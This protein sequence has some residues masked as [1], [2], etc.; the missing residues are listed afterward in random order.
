MQFCWN[1][2]IVAGSHEVPFV[3]IESP[4][5][6]Y[7]DSSAIDG[8]FN[9]KWALFTEVQKSYCGEYRRTMRWWPET[10][11]NII[12]EYV[13][14]FNPPSNRSVVRKQC[15]DCGLIVKLTGTE[16]MPDRLTLEKEITE[17][18]TCCGKTFNEGK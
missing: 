18:W 14:T 15:S 2:K 10:I 9:L 4:L 3:Q 6:G 17:T 16:E 11:E 12:L 8:G 13:G 7:L 5:H 1:C